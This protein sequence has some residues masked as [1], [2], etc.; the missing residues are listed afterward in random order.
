MTGIIDYGGGNSGS[1]ANALARLGEPFRLV[2]THSEIA[3]SSR[4]ILPGVGHFGAMLAALDRRGLRAPILAAI[5]AGVPFLG[6]CVGLQALYAGSEE[7][8]N[9]CGLAVWSGTIR[10]FASGQGYKIPHVGWAEVRAAAPSRL[11]EGIAHGERFYFTHSYYAPLGEPTTGTVQYPVPFTAV[12]ERGNVAAVQFHPEKSGAAG[13]RVL[14]NFLNLAA[15]VPGLAKRII[16]C[17]DVKDG[18]VV[19]GVQFAGLR[20]SGDPAERAR[21]YNAAGADELVMLDIAATLES[22]P[23]LLET[24]RRVAAELQLPFCVGGGV[25]TLADAAAL[26][27]AG[28]DKVAVNSAA[29][30]RPELINEIAAAFGSQAVVVAIDARGGEVLSHG[31]TRPTGRAAVEWARQAEAAGAGEILLTSMDRDGTRSGF[32]CVLTASVAATAGIPV[33]AS[34][35]GGAASDFVEVF[36]PGRADA[37]LAASIFHTGTLPIEQLKRELEA[38]GIPVR[39]TY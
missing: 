12:A 10:R 5:A 37:A 20:D 36:G 25:R 13:E 7:D 19:K 9:A 16:P 21:A 1:V 28:A 30:A 38:A 4:L 15:P 32:D 31:G 23:T 14:R 11:L 39:R 22:R 18:R 26:L 33:I 2:G 27:A 35:G 29:L 17:L 24:V 34:G 3:A 6:I 8:G